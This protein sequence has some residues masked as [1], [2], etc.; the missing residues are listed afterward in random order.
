[1]MLSL[2][3][4]LLDVSAFADDADDVVVEDTGRVLYVKNGIDIDCR[5]LSED[6]SLPD[7]VRMPDGTEMPYAKFLTHELARLDVLAGKLVDLRPA[8]PFFVDGEASLARPGDQAV[9]G[10]SVALL[11]AECRDAPAFASRVSFLTADAG[12]GKTALLRHY[13]REVAQSFQKGKSSFLF[14]HVDLQGRQLLR[15]SEA[16]MGDLGELRHAG[17]WMPG[18]VRLMQHKKL[19]LA[20]DGF[21]ELSAEQGDA[22]ALG[23]LTSLVEQLEG[24]GVIIAAAR[25]TFFDAEDYANK[26]SLVRRGLASPCHFD[27]MKLSPWGKQETV[28]FLSAV[29]FDGQSF[30]DPEKT[31]SNIVKAL[32][33]DQEHPMLDR[34]FLLSQMA[35]VLLT[36]RLAPEDFVTTD[37]D[38]LSGVASVVRA[39]IKREV[40]EKWI[41]PDTGAPYLTQDQHVELLASVAEEMYRNQKDRLRLD[42]IETIAAMLM[43]QWSIAPSRQAQIM[44][45]VRA[46]VLLVLPP[47]EQSN[48]RSFDHPEFRDFF[49]AQ[50]LRGHL[51]TALTDGDAR[52]LARFLTYA[53]LTD[54]TARYVCAMVDRSPAR[55]DRAVRSLCE[56]VREEWRPT[57][58]QPNAGTLVAS[59]LDGVEFE[60]ETAVDAGLVVSSLV[61]EQS[62]LQKVRFSGVNFVNL[63]L[64]HADWRDVVLSGCE[65]TELRLDRSL[66]RFHNVLVEDTRIS[67]VKVAVDSEEDEREYSPRRIGLLLKSMGIATAA[68]EPMIE[69]PSEIEETESLRTG[70]RLFSLFARSTTVTDHMI[71][72]RFRAAST[73]GFVLNTVVPLL[74]RHGL[75]EERPWRGGGTGRV[76]MLRRGLDE[77]LSAVDQPNDPAHA[78][79]RELAAA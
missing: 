12:H 41:F 53:P 62:R 39:F 79:W 77:I 16:L 46:H 13:Q 23:A 25:R 45:M 48:F 20:V 60:E 58:L 6:G 36:S 69:A 75:I 33:G 27:Q 30:G 5:V 4:V 42:T 63:S 47:D 24:R 73:A 15:L 7:R 35:K 1:M 51:E 14:W 31:Y 17:L 67:C 3:E 66:S 19:I 32:G 29:E 8:V 43:D 10:K 78:F 38:P 71:E 55:A 49:V 44:D 64:Q 34:P 65:V 21:D 11:E 37:D 76:W 54:G 72:T 22:D 9:Q 40:T 18:I 50:A 70:R 28:R 59:L 61:L 56:R 2:K 68:Q 52:Q 57:H 26:T 74:T